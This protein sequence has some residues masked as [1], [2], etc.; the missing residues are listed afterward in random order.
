MFISNLLQVLPL[1][2]SQYF[3][4]QKSKLQQSIQLS[5]MSVRLPWGHGH[6]VRTLNNNE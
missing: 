4:A 2:Q 5:H 6:K 3:Q 1:L